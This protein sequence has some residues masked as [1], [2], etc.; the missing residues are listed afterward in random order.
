MVMVVNPLFVS[1]RSFATSFTGTVAQTSTK[2][3]QRFSQ[4][5][6]QET[7]FSKKLVSFFRVWRINGLI[8]NRVTELSVI[9]G[10][11]SKVAFELV[12]IVSGQFTSVRLCFY[13]L[14]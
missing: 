12:C 2:V 8:S 14:R 7:S 11:F 1:Q 6:R 3:S 13:W 9:C 10:G 5:V 4:Q